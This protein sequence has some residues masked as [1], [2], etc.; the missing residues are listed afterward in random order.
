M[1]GWGGWG[2]RAGRITERRNILRSS[3]N[4]KN[5]INEPGTNMR[6]PPPFPPHTHTHTHQHKTHKQPP[7][8]IHIHAC[9][10]THTHTHLNKHAHT[11]TQPPPPI[12]NQQDT[13][14]NASRT[15]PSAVVSRKFLEVRCLKSL[16]AS[17]HR[18]HDS[19]PW[20]FEHLRKKQRSTQVKKPR[21]KRKEISLQDSTLSERKTH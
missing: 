18:A 15:I 14:A 12:V 1:G 5:P 7:P 4:N 21:K 9:T 6:N 20:L 8:P 3:F 11:L 16:V 10:N 13:N 17:I 19:R 2:G